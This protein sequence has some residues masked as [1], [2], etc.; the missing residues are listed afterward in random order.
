MKRF[1]A[2]ILLTGC[3]PTDAE[4][5]GDWFAWLAANSSATV[6]EEGIADIR[7]KSTIF[8]CKRGWDAETEL[9]EPGYIGPTQDDDPNDAR[10]VGGDCDPDDSDCTAAEADMQAECDEIDALEWYSFLQDDGY[11]GLSGEFEAW[12]TEA[13]L[14]GEGDF[15]LTAHHR[16]GNGSDFRFAFAIKPTF[17]PVECVTNDSGE[18]EIQYVDG[19][20][21]VDAWS[22]DEDGHS[23]YYLN[24]G[25][26]QANPADDEEFWYVITDWSSGAGQA[27]FG[28]EEF[29]HD[30]TYYQN[31][32]L[33]LEDLGEEQIDR[34]DPDASLAEPAYTAWQDTSDLYVDELVSVAG[35][36]VGEEAAFSH[37][38]ETNEWRE[39][40]R[41][42][43]GFDGWIDTYNSW[44]R[45]K[46]GSKFEQGGTVEG[47]YQIYYVGFESASRVLVSG[48]FKVDK[49]REDPWAYPIL[50][51]EKR[52]ENETAFCGGAAMP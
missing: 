9:F 10:F 23:I 42:D 18:A 39:M 8:D 31:V 13:M 22:E 26:A 41:S 51:N 15:Q 3:K 48:T 27:K 2:L 7:D 47:D 30:T 14:N 49:L 20:S 1:L 34:E 40:D 52:E 45:I 12:R 37:K 46:D 35:A 44:V 6:A 28:A 16:L 50:E 43:S 17:A 25:S 4:L 29:L 33:L 5:N 19:Q 32:N 21:W 11:Y 38:L 24:S 36:Q